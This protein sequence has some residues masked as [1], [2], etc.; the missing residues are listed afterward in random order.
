MLTD[1]HICHH[2]TTTTTTRVRA[3]DEQPEGSG[4]QD[5]QQKGS[6]AVYSLSHS[7]LSNLKHLYEM[8]HVINSI[9]KFTIQRK[10]YGWSPN[11]NKFHLSYVV[12]SELWPKKKVDNFW[13]LILSCMGPGPGS[14]KGV[15][16]DLGQSM[17]VK[18]EGIFF[19]FGT[20]TCHA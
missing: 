8:L 17:E 19:F 16:P 14:T 3:Q 9:C 20:H 10:N 2:C 5:G 11:Y 1:C 6:K 13:W 4:A 15:T 7:P 18:G 12:L